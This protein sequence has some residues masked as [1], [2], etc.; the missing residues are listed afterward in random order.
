MCIHA[1]QTES[2]TKNPADKSPPHKKPPNGQ[3]APGLFL[4]CAES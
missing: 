4:E 2:R 3:K 1:S